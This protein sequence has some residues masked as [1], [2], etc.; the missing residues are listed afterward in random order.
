MKYCIMKDKMK[1]LVLAIATL[2][3]L[4]PMISCDDDATTETT[5]PQIRTAIYHWILIDEAAE[6]PENREQRLSSEVG[7]YD[8]NGHVIK[9]SDYAPYEHNRKLTLEY[10]DNGNIVDMVLHKYSEVNELPRVRTFLRYDD[11]GN[12]TESF[13]E[14]CEEDCQLNEPWNETKW[15]DRVEPVDSYDDDG[16]LLARFEY[17]I[18][19]EII[20]ERTY[21][22]ETDGNLVEDVHQNIWL[23]SKIKETFAYSANGDLT[24]RR[25]YSYVHDEFR[26]NTTIRYDEAGNEIESF[27]YVG[28]RNGDLT[29]YECLEY[30]EYGNWTKRTVVA[31]YGDKIRYFINLR[32]LEYYGENGST[33]LIPFSTYYSASF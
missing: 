20:A 18:D 4:M 16:N 10:D 33:E 9:Q 29:T 22:Y 32:Y 21:R 7:L 6:E 1:L 8:R 12:L 23:S 26:L 17:D 14:S 19:G 24:E 3:I 27:N 5:K 13:S 28:K 25:F 11:R 15:P 31:D 2:G 30:D